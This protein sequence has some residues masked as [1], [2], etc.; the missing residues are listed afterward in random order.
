MRL[1]VLA[2][3]AAWAG[4]T[5]LLSEV[6]FFARRP[7]ADRLEAYAQEPVSRSGRLGLLSVESFSQAVG[8]L[9]RAV[10]ALLSRALGVEEELETRLRRIHSTYDG[11]SF[12]VR[13]VGIA[14]ATMGAAALA[15][16]AWRPS[17]AV[18]LL[19]L[20]GLPLLALLLV[21]QQLANASAA[22]QRRLQLELPVIAE[23][24]GMLLA[25]GWS[26]NAALN[27]VARRGDGACAQDLRRVVQRARQGLADEVALREWA[28]LAR[29]RGVDRLVAVLVLN[30]ETTDLGSLVGDEARSI[31][32][33]VQRE[34]IESVERKAQQVWIPVTVATLVPGVIFVSIPFIRAMER[35]Q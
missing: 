1:L 34:L 33:D 11:T 35:L 24:I 6:R 8:P 27:R 15:T 29:V 18:G 20:L 14:T 12:R 3:I 19:L 25:A 5:L 23:Q 21:E 7:V 4:L 16:A 13:Q 31:R 32:R 2:G 10:G 28:E 26:L 22:W 30:R 17:V 9:A